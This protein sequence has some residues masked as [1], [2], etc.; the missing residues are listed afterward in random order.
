MD[1]NVSEEYTASICAV[2]IHGVKKRLDGQEA[3]LSETLVSPYESRRYHNLEGH[4]PNAGIPLQD[5]TI[6][7]SRR[8][9]SKSWYHPTR[10]DDITI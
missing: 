8:P 3:C 2:K 7:Q 4:N 10:P 6:S 5:Q 9:Q 1:A